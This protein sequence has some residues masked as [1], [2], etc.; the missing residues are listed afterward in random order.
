[1][2]VFSR[3]FRRLMRPALLG[4]FC[5]GCA[6]SLLG[7]PKFDPSLTW[8][9]IAT[10]HFVVYYHQGEEDWA[11]KAARIAEEVHSTLVPKLGWA[12]AEPTHVI[13]VDNEDT[14]SDA[15]TPF[16]N[17]TIYIGLTTPLADTLPFPERYDDWLRDVISH[18]YVHI[19]QLDMNTGLS[20]LMRTV[21]GRQP[22]PFFIFNSALP[23][24]LQPDWLIEGLATYEETATGVSDRWDNAYAE[25][26]LRM[27]ILDNRFPT[28]DQAGGRDT[29]PDHQIQYIF[30]ARFL[31]YLA[32]RFG[33]NVLKELSLGYS[34]KV[35][36]FFVGTNGRQVLGQSYDSLWEDWKTELTIRYRRQRNELEAMGFTTSRP[37]SH[38]GDY[39]LGPRTNPKDGRV[40]YTRVNPHEYP[41]I[42][43]IDPETGQDRFLIRRSYGYTISWSTDGRRM[44]FSQLEVYRNSSV[45]SDLY[46]FDLASKKLRRLTKGARLRDPDFHPDGSRLICVENRLGKNRLVIFDLTTGRSEV[47]NWAG[48]DEIWFHPRWSPDG[49]SVAVSVWKDGVQGL[50]LLDMDHR[51]IVPILM[52][53][54]LD[55]S[56]TWSPDGGFVLFSTDRTGIYNLFAYSVKTSELFQVTNVLGGAFTPEVTPD[57]REIL[58]SGYSSAGFD[59]HRMPWDPTSWKKVEIPAQDPKPVSLVPD[60]FPELNAAP[61]S[62]WPTLRPRFWTPIF[63]SDESGS[64]IGAA[65]GGMDVLGR[66]KFDAVALYGTSTHRA[67]Y[68]LQYV[69]DAFYPSLHVGIIDLAVKHSDLPTNQPNR[70]Y[71]YWERQQRLDLDMTLLRTLFQTGQSVT[72]GYQLERLS[73]LADIPIDAVPPDEGYLSGLRLVWRLDTAHEYGFSISPEDGRRLQ[74]GYERFDHRM[75]SDF[76]QNRYI[77]SWH[78]YHGM[79]FPHH[80][81]AARLTG[82]LATGDRMIQGDFQVGGPNVAEVF[83]DPEQTDFFLRGYP[84][85]LSRGQKAAVGTLEYRFPLQN[86]EHGISTWPFF[87]QRTHADLFF[88]IGNAWDHHTML[89]DFRRGIGLEVEMDTIL[90]HLLPI[91]ARLGFAKGLDDGG[92]RQTYFAVGNSF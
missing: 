32:R 44:V 42:H 56:P 7:G 57:G 49:K 36:P 61:Y 30:G 39:V 46:L 17:S 84:A 77:A 85:R 72:F 51:E 28:L 41:S 29:W 87:L 78:E 89:S 53:P 43:W 90:G 71:S 86:V 48:E 81:L 37:F 73:G 45:F 22:V 50:Y 69:N 52:D 40:A 35:F 8:N 59:L 60:A 62:P 21:F 70:T 25:M 74:A 3:I 18:E 76:D 15:A 88:D 14:I 67:A 68:S 75:G 24:I 12:P 66:H 82:A 34:G 80:V 6:I 38:Q 58:F 65:T 64:Q 33:E 2:E 20:S 4:L 10:P 13:L 9:V 55:L 91:R 11:R 79:F 27:A 31:D 26:L 92:E 47:L 23:N 54:A 5:T 16:P 1:M 19:L 63:G 83:L